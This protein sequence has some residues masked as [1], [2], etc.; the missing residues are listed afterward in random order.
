MAELIKTNESLV[1]QQKEQEK[2]ALEVIA[3][4]QSGSEKKDG[5]IKSLNQQLNDEREAG[6]AERDRILQQAQ[7]QIGGGFPR[8]CWVLMMKLTFVR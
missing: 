5:T 4:L 2:D 1:E 3:A 8:V 7:K 6:E